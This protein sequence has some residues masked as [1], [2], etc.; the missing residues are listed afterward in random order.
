[1]EHFQD[2]AWADYVRGVTS[3]PQTAAMTA[4]LGTSCHRCQQTIRAFGALARL[5]LT[6]TEEIPPE[7]VLHNARAIFALLR[8]DSVQVLPRFYGSLMYDSFRTPLPA[9]VRSG[10]PISRQVL[11]EAGP[12]WID[13]RLDHERG[14]RRAWLT[15]QIASGDASHRID[16]LAVSLTIAGNVAAQASTNAAGEFQLDY[17]PGGQVQLRIDG[18]P[19]DR[20]ELPALS[21]DD[22]PPEPHEGGS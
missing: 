8:P 11:Y 5:A 15:G 18:L 9:G 2:T 16:G 1:M 12:Y 6:E 4:H 19:D 13:L 20:I 14:S 21:Q 17:E 10:Q 7:H 3:E 22:D